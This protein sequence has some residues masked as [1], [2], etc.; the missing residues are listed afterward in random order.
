MAWLLIHTANDQWVASIANTNVQFNFL[1][2]TAQQ[3]INSMRVLAF[4][5][6]G[7]NE[8]VLTQ[9]IR[10]IFAVPEGVEEQV[11]GELFGNTNLM[12]FGENIIF[13]SINS[14]EILIDSLAN[15]AQALI[16]AIAALG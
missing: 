3:Q 1:G 5:M 10:N 7:A 11:V 2:A 15:A 16:E 13:G 4:N 8:E 14:G 6:N 9:N 12:M